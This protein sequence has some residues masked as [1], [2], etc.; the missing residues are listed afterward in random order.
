MC[1]SI[2][3]DSYPRLNDEN[4]KS[5][6]TAEDVEHEGQGKVYPVNLFPVRLDKRFLLSGMHIRRKTCLHVSIA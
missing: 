5:N 1:I 3:T 2:L 4:K 6:S